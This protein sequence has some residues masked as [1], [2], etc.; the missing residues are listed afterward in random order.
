M[1]LSILKDVITRTDFTVERR[2][3]YYMSFGV[4]LVVEIMK[5]ITEWYFRLEDRLVDV[6][7]MFSFQIPERTRK[8]VFFKC[9]C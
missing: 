5:Q 4:P 8:E 9:I 6:Y 2:F 7:L 3:D 1:W